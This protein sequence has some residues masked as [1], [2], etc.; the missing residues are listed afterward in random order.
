MKWVPKR[1]S[2][3]AVTFGG[4]PPAVWRWWEWLGWKSRSRYYETER[5]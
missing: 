1:C 4:S 5:Y 2:R 3:T